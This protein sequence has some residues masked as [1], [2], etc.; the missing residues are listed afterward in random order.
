MSAKGVSESN[1]HFFIV[2]NGLSEAIDDHC[3]S[4]QAL[5]DEFD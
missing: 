3:P 5:I 2:P 4:A 1:G